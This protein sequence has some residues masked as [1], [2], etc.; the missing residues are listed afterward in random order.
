MNSWLALP[1][2]SAAGRAGLGLGW[3]FVAVS[4]WLGPRTGVF[5]LS[6]A[7]VVSA[8]S[9]PESELDES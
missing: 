1:G 7:P 3:A 4:K 2:F 9:R 8:G 6:D 5:T